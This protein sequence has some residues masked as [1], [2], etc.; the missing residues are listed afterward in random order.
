MHNLKNNN[1]NILLKYLNFNS[2]QLPLSILA[3]SR[4]EP[5]ALG[6]GFVTCV[7]QDSFDQ[8]LIIAISI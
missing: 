4:G 8:I 5:S 3:K 7:K 1:K 2:V 6:K